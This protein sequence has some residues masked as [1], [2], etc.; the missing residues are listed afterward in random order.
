MHRIVVLLLFTSCASYKYQDI[1]KEY[2]NGKISLNAVLNMARSS[3]LK[4]C[5]EN[6][7]HDFEKCKK[8]AQK[9]SS[10]IATILKED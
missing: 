3:Y 6:S 7:K 4:G 9:H 2:K 10:D 8:L 1:K 5:T